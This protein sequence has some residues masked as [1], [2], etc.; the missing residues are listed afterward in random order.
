MQKIAPLLLAVTALLAV[1]QP[2][3]AQWKWKDANGKIQY[4]DMPPPPGTPAANILQRPPGAPPIQIVTLQDGKPVNTAAPAASTPASAP[5]TKAELDAQARK[6]QEAA[7]QLAKQKAEDAKFAAQKRDN[8]ARARDNL[9]TLESGV[10]MRTGQNGDFMSD[11]MRAAEIQRTRAV[12]ASDC[13][14]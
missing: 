7:D 1:S 14:P 12:V 8:C 3:F 5:P 13:A 4:S 11:E 10:R 6:K 9:A 2:A